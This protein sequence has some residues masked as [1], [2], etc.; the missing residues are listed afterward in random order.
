MMHGLINEYFLQ[1]TSASCTCDVHDLCCSH[2]GICKVNVACLAAIHWITALSRW[3]WLEVRQSRLILSVF[4]SAVTINDRWSWSQYTPDS[5]I[6][7]RFFKLQITQD[8]ENLLT[9]GNC[10]IVVQFSDIAKCPH[11]LWDC[12]V[13]TGGCNPGAKAAG[14]WTSLPSS[15]EFRMHGAYLHRLVLP[16]NVH[17]DNFSFTLRHEKLTVTHVI[18]KFLLV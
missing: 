4:I 14:T 15:A 18:K 16:H 7:L 5:K 8:S 12:S 10:E 3:P 9:A 6:W 11:G 13:C 2:L 17:R 1:A